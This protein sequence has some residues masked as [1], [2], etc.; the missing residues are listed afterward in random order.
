VTDSTGVAPGT[1]EFVKARETYTIA[2]LDG[3]IKKPI[4]PEPEPEPVVQPRGPFARSAKPK[5]V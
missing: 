3:R 4:P 1:P 5:Q 2:R